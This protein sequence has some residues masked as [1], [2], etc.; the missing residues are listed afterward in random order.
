MNTYLFRK[1]NREL[2][3]IRFRAI[4]SAL[5]I[6]FAVAMYIGMAAMVPSASLTLDQLVE[7]GRLSDL[8]V[9]VDSSDVERL[10]SLEQVPGVLST[11][12]RLKEVF[13]PVT[14]AL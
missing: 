6:F 7:E 5:L 4:G 1:M 8:I 10:G 14:T 9:R 2:R 12:A 13:S 3:R 11:E